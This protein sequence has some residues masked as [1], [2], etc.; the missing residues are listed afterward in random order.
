MLSDG[1]KAHSV[2]NLE[3]LCDDVVCGHGSTVGP[4][5]EEHLYYL[6][7]RG[8]SQERAERVLLRGFFQEIIDRLPAP[9]VAAASDHVRSTAK[10]VLAQQEGRI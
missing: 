5:E 4:L 3:I 6:Q 10:F 7:S 2:P 9:Q 1:A 8:L